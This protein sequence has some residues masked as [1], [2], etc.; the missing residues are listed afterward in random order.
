M[1]FHCLAMKFSFIKHVSF[2]VIKTEPVSQNQ[3]KLTFF[4]IKF[5]FVKN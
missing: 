4:D 2:T 5:G 3:L 1:L